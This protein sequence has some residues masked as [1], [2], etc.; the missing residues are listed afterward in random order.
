MCL[1]MPAR[2]YDSK[3]VRPVID[4]GV[5]QD[6]SSKSTKKAGSS[7][8]ESAGGGPDAEDTSDST[9]PCQTVRKSGCQD[10][11]RLISQPGGRGPVRTSHRAPIFAASYH[12]SLA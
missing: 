6:E 7:A 1:Q 4:K 11:R 3:R 5:D 2:F 8:G 12:P 10:P 9:G